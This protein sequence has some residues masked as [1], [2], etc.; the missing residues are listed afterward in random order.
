MGISRCIACG[1]HFSARPQNPQQSYC[2]TAKCQRERRRRWQKEKRR[3]DPD[4]R[5]EQVRAQKSW[6]E[7]HPDYWRQYRDKHPEYVE[8]NRVQQRARHQS[9]RKIVAKMN[10][11]TMAPP[12]TDGIY[13]LNRLTQGDLAKMDTW[14]V[15]IQVVSPPIA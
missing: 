2:S 8:K 9:K 7:Q 11:S 10:A 3:A 12:L 14:T 4:Y 1:K 5:E 6:A 13:I 15:R